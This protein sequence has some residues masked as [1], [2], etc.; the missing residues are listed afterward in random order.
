[1]WQ[2]NYF[3]KMLS[4]TSDC[5]IFLYLGV[6]DIFLNKIYHININTNKCSIQIE[7]G[8]CNCLIYQ[9]IQGWPS[10]KVTTGTQALSVGH[11]SFA[12]LLGANPSPFIQ[13]TNNLLSLQY[14]RILKGVW[15]DM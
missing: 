6:T 3:I 8:S 11:F 14:K 13:M 7:F 4:S 2:V 9:F 12:S 5:I 1:M 10:S 15:G